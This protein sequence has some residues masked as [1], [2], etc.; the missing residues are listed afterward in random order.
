M[1]RRHPMQI[2]EAA[3]MVVGDV[4]AFV[5]CHSNG[6]TDVYEQYC[7]AVVMDTERL[8]R[9]RGC[10]HGQADQDDAYILSDLL[11]IKSVFSAAAATTQTIAG[12][13][14]DDDIIP[15]TV[16]L[17]GWVPDESKESE[18]MIVDW[19]D[20]EEYCKENYSF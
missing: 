5:S 18:S 10:W 13:K 8:L 12:S 17:D 11:D 2:M 9:S 1:K 6:Y 3:E 14:T 7:I 4:Y 16:H 15:F 20:D 19:T